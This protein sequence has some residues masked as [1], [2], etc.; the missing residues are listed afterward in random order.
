MLA[1]C[2]RAVAQRAGIQMGEAIASMQ[3]IVAAAQRMGDI[4]GVIEGIA[5][6]TYILALKAAV[7][8]ARAGESRRSFAAEAAEVRALAQRAGKA[9]REIKTLISD[10]TQ[11]TE[12]G[13][14]QVCATGQTLQQ[15]VAE[16]RQLSGLMLRL[17]QSSG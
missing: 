13:S 11:R 16:I 1:D 5:S 6:Q 7:E 14:R 15:M 8:A 10:T 17:D 3:G 9:E 12:A 2:T 4:T